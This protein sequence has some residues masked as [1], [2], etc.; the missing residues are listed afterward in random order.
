MKNCLI[1]NVDV[2]VEWN[3]SIFVRNGP[4]QGAVFKFTIEFPINYP[5]ESPDVVF[6]TFEKNKIWHPQ[7]D[8]MMGFLDLGKEKN[9]N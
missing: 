5:H 3:G 4:F 6:E 8:E 1:L 9:L 7:I 2:D